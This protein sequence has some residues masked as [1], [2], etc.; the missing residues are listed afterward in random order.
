MHAFLIIATSLTL[1]WAPWGQRLL[2]FFFH[3]RIPITWNR[4]VRQLSFE[5]IVIEWMSEWVNQSGP[6][7]SVLTLLCPGQGKSPAALSTFEARSFFGARLLLPAGC[8]TASACS[9]PYRL[10]EPVPCP[11]WQSKTSLDVAERPLVGKCPGLRAA[12]AVPGWLSWCRV[13]IRN[14]ICEWLKVDAQ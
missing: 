7:L 4:P 12:R 10:A 14:S 1:Q 11:E 8:L 6:L 2:Y 13:I 9:T 5:R 3:F